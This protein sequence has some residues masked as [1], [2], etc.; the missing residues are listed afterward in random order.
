MKHGFPLSFASS[1]GTLVHIPALTVEAD[2]L[3]PDAKQMLM[4]HLGCPS[5]QKHE[6]KVV[7]F[8]NYVVSG[9]PL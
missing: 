1:T 9:V 4:P 5:I 2:S 8:R 6:P 7:S 3:L